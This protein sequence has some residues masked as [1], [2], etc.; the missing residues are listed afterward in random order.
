MAKPN[1]DELAGMVHGAVI[2]ETPDRH[3]LRELD[4]ASV[5][6][7]HSLA[8][9]DVDIQPGVPWAEARRPD[10]GLDLSAAEVHAERR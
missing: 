10:D 9:E 6:A 5:V 3:Q 1:S 4:D 2:D 7:D 8:V